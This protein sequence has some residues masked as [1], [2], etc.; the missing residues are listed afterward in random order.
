[1]LPWFETTNGSQNEKKNRI[2]KKEVPTPTTTCK[3]KRNSKKYKIK[4]RK[5]HY[6]KIKKHFKRLQEKQR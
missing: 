4:Q 2:E 6:K 5:I 1:M 3:N